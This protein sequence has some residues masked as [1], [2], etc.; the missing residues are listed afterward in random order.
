MVKNTKRRWDCV[1]AAAPR[2]RPAS[3]SAPVIWYSASDGARRSL[4]DPLT[5]NSQGDPS[6]DGH[7]S[8]EPFV[9]RACWRREGD[10]VVPAMVIACGVLVG[11]DDDAK[12]GA[13]PAARCLQH[14][15]SLCAA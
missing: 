10:G 8:W 15:V 3:P 9:G 11:L 4:L 1:R 12:S 13:V 14:A 7:Q 6:D 2:G 5:G